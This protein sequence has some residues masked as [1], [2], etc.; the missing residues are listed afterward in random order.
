[1]NIK[2]VSRPRLGEY[3]TTDRGYSEILHK[4]PVITVIPEDL[5]RDLRKK[6]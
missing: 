6:F 1:L 2:I 3:Y 4:E 5:A